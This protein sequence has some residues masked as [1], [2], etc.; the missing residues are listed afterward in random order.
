[1]SIESRKRLVAARFEGEADTWRQVHSKRIKDIIQLEIARRKAIAREFIQ[2]QFG[3]KPISIL[4]IGCGAGQ[5]LEEIVY[6]DARRQGKGVDVAQAMIESCR[7]QYHSKNR[8]SFETL[9]IDTGYLNG[10][11]DVIMLLGVVGYLGS[12]RMAFQNIQRMLRPG[13]YVIL[14]FGKK[15]S[16]ARLCRSLYQRSKDLVRRAVIRIA[17][18]PLFGGRGSRENLFRCF[19]LSEIKRCFPPDWRLI[20]SFNLAFG[21]GILP[22]K[23]INA[24]LERLFSRRDPLGLALSALIIALRHP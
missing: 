5:N 22:P 7:A 23:R 15:Y 8:I 6:S 20:S 4:E 16:L 12:N 11:F 24:L 1:M 21:I 19:S 14:T 10:Q 3:G 2:Q 17:G 9:D 18:Q 13:G